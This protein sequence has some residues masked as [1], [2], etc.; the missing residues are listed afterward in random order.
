MKT[1]DPGTPRLRDAM[2]LLPALAVFLLMPPLVTLFAGSHH[3]GGVPL[4]VVYLFGVWLA[5][6]VAAAL[7][8]RRL[9]RTPDAGPAPA[10]PA[11]LQAAASADA[12][13]TQPP[14]R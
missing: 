2:A 8:A 10:V 11:S 13:P 3:L 4:I 9:A 1:P 14:A 6:I 5:L 7:L 12:P